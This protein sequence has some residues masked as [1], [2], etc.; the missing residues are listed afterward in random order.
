MGQVCGFEF[1]CLR[2]CFLSFLFITWTYGDP[3][4]TQVYLL[5]YTGT[6]LVAAR[7]G[8]VQE[9]ARLIGAKYKKKDLGLNQMV[10]CIKIT[11]DCVI[12]KSD[13]NW[14]YG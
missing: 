12:G 4:C 11:R 14:T 2:V 5:L 3:V 8:G 6:M 13:I 10:W 9:V 7:H 1:Y